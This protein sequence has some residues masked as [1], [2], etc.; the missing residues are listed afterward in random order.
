MNAAFWEQPARLMRAIGRTATWKGGRQ[1]EQIATGSLAQMVHQIAAQDSEEIWRF[2]I[3]TGDGHHIR[4]ADLRDLV[5]RK[6][7]PRTEQ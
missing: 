1:P 2:I 3:V 5:R 7:L 6:D 4:S